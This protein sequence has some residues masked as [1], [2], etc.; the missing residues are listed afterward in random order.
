MSYIGEERRGRVSTD[1]LRR[2]AYMGI[3]IGL[4]AVGVWLVFK[5]VAGIALP[6]LGGWAI[7]LCIRPAASWINRKSKMPYKLAAILLLLTLMLF[8]GYGLALGIGKIVGELG[9]FAEKLV[10]GFDSED[11]VLHKAADLLKSIGGKIP[12]LEKLSGENE[13]LVNTVYSMIESAVSELASRISAAATEFAGGIVK[14]L[15][16]VAFALVTGILTGFYLTLDHD[17]FRDS[18]MPILPSGAIETMSNMRRGIAEAVGGF[19]KASLTMMLITFGGLFLG[20]VI[21]RVDYSLLL[22]LI[23]SVVDFLPVFGVGTVLLPWSAFCFIGGDYKLGLGLIVLYGVLYA[24]RQFVEPHLMGNFIGLHPLV[25]LIAVYAGFKLFG[26]V[27]MILAPPAVYIVKFI[28]SGEF[29]ADK[30]NKTAQKR[31]A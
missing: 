6:F 15:P 23:I 11:N 20:F 24:V 22:A 14:A 30:K 9:E 5:Y 26:V 27:G 8:L 17:K 16:G 18:L 13:S 12:F 4:A 3:C 21:L 19:L 1:T 2:Y 29:A 31:E 25:A 10:S 7:S 28:L